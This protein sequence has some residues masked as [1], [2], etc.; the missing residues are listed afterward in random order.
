M[1]S[2][3]PFEHPKRLHSV[4]QSL[5]SSLSRTQP[6]PL[7]CGLH[8]SPQVVRGRYSNIPLVSCLAAG[9]AQYH[10]SCGVALVDCVLE[11]IRVGLENPAAGGRGAC[12]L[13]ALCTKGSCG[14]W[15]G[16]WWTVCCRTS[17]RKDSRMTYMWFTAAA[18]C[19]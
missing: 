10:E 7:P 14:A 4:S 8:P 19:Q 5:S 9:L 3:K 6:V 16:R 1:G 11:D 15:E 12:V 18:A 13:A 2:A 17:R